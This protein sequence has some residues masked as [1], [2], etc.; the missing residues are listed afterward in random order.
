MGYVA[1]E[2]EITSTFVWIVESDI[3]WAKIMEQTR[4]TRQ[5]M[6]VITPEHKQVVIPLLNVHV[7]LAKELT[8][9]RK[10]ML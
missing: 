9:I 7:P 2:Y 10:G 6:Q 8:Q 3:H 1:V 4:Q 5:S